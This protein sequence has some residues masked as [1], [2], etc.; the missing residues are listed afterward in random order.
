MRFPRART[1][2]GFTL[3]EACWTTAIFGVL[4]AA[5]VTSL[6][7]WTEAHDHAGTAARMQVVLR[8]T[9]QRAVTEG[10]PMCVEFDT[11]AQAYNVYRG[12]C[13]SGDKIIL[14]GPIRP[15]GSGPRI[16]SPSFNG[17]SGPTSGVTFAPRGTAWPGTVRVT[18][19]GS[20]RVWTVGVEGLTGRVSRA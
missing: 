11:A 18:R 9:Q 17:P 13:D 10:R 14:E 15:Q 7:G 8:E 20:D 4:A 2:A 19:P 6:R 5:S 12:A 3:V 16:T 1:D